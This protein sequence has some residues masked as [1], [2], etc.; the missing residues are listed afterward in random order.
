MQKKFGRLYYPYSI[1]VLNNVST[2]DLILQ[3]NLESTKNLTCILQVQVK[4][5]DSTEYERLAIVWL[6]CYA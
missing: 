2:Q 3:F 1:Y 6:H 5:G 4:S